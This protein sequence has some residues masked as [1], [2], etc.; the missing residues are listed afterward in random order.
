MIGC[1]S[2]AHEIEH[3]STTPTGTESVEHYRRDKFRRRG[4]RGINRLAAI[5][6]VVAGIVFIV[7]VIFWSGFVLGASAGHHQDGNEGGGGQH[8]SKMMQDGPE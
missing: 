5:I 3:E 6:A 4:G 8:N 7:A 1:M 2:E